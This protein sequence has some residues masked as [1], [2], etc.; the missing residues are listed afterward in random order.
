M[1]RR[2][3]DDH[4]RELEVENRNGKKG[5]QKSRGEISQDARATT[6]GLRHWRGE[7]AELDHGYGEGMRNVD[8]NLTEKTDG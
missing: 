6:A 8:G 7:E 2:E 5:L 3:D 1:L 4:T